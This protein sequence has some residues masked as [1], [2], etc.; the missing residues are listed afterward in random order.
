MAERRS[1]HIYHS[2]DL[3]RNENVHCSITA[4]CTKTV[5]EFVK[6]SF[7]LGSVVLILSIG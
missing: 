1:E 4:N 7:T 6:C 5:T 2:T 3:S